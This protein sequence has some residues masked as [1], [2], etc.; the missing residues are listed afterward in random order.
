MLGAIWAQ[1]T[2]GVIGFDGGM[3]WHIPEDLAHFKEIT[4]KYPVIM[5]RRTWESLPEKV[6]PLPG[7]DNLILSS[8][9]AGDWSHGA[10]VLARLPE[11]T[12]D[13]WIMGGA[14][15]YAKTLADVDVLEVT[16]ID[17]RLR[18]QLGDAAALAP[19]ISDAFEL[20]RE[21]EWQASERGRLRLGGRHEAAGPVHYRF[22]R[23]ERK[24]R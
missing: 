17:A 10:R 16:E 12:E 19:T 5:G 14:Q 3:P 8:R 7:R 4:L 24:E 15:V 21:T 11:I 18:N 2:D 20:V 22:Q 6:R 1:T 23:Y 13:T 9:P